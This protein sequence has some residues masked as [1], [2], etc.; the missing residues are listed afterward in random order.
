MNRA[1]HPLHLVLGLVR[2]G[3]DR[4]ERLGAEELAAHAK[5]AGRI[6]DGAPLRRSRGSGRDAR[7]APRGPR[8]DRHLRV[9]VL[10]IEQERRRAR[11][12][13]ALV[14][15][16]NRITDVERIG[17]RDAEARAGPLEDLGL[18]L[19]GLLDRR[20]GERR[21]R[22]GESPRASSSRGQVRV[23]VRDDGERR[24]SRAARCFERRQDVADRSSRSLGPRK[25]A[26]RRAYASGETSPPSRRARTRPQEVRQ[27]SGLAAD[28]SVPVA[29]RLGLH[30]GPRPEQGLTQLLRRKTRAVLA[31]TRV[32]RPP[33]REDPDGGASRRRRSRPRGSADERVLPHHAVEGPVQ[34][35]RS[36]GEPPRAPSR[37]PPACRP[38]GRAPRARPRRCHTSASS[39]T[40]KKRVA[41]PS[42]MP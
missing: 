17:R 18:G 8:C 20:N 23:P 27:N 40:E 24:G 26:A 37:A 22:N 29:G 5:V 30:L 7:R 14:V 2:V 13:R 42:R 6:P 1:E 35:R 15:V 19:S 33:R 3:Q 21:E 38:R 4:V 9:A 25:C 11:G 12:A 41:S 16:A 31:K 10:A 39:W 28:A 34:A 36:S 32:R